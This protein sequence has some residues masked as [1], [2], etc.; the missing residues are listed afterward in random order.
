MTKPDNISNFILRSA[1]H[2]PKWQASYAENKLAFK[3]IYQLQYSQAYLRQM[4][5]LDLGLI[6]RLGMLEAPGPRQAP[7]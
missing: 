1:A 6:R 7:R 5:K 2:H 3:M 4:I